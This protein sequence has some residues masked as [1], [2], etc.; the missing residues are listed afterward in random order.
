MFQRFTRERRIA[1]IFKK[2]G[3]HD[4]KPVNLICTNS[5]LFGGKFVSMQKISLL[6]HK[7]SRV[8]FSM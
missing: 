5:Q 7:I 1:M 8:F 2:E 6:R 3:A 4:V